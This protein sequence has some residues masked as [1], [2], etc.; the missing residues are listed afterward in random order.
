MYFTRLSRIFRNA[1]FGGIDIKMLEV[2]GTSQAITDFEGLWDGFVEILVKE[3][4]TL[5]IISALLLSY[6]FETRSLS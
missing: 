1:K 3:W 6:V 4:K 5:N 2:N